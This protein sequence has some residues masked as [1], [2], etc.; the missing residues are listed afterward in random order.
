MR[1]EKP[2]KHVPRP[3]GSRVIDTL[4]RSDYR[5]PFVW[6]I[7]SVGSASDDLLAENSKNDLLFE[8]CS[9]RSP[10]DDKVCV[11]WW[12]NGGVQPATYF[13]SFIKEETSA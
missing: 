10:S 2:C 13:I 6:R 7:C 3:Q 12:K 11:L 5:Q 9:R 1:V 4:Q 8:W